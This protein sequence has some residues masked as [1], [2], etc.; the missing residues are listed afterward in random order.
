MLHSWNLRVLALCLATSLS[1]VSA[2]DLS[3]TTGIETSTDLGFVAPSTEVALPDSTTSEAVVDQAPSSATSEPQVQIPFTSADEETTHINVAPASSE[4]SSQ[5]VEPTTNVA[6][7]T[8]TTESAGPGVESSSQ[9]EQLPDTAT[10]DSDIPVNTATGHPVFPK[11]ITQETEFSTQATDATPVDQPSTEISGSPSEAT[12][13]ATGA[14]THAATDALT[15]VQPPVASTESTEVVD[16]TTQ[17]TEPTTQLPLPEATTE[18]SSALQP[19]TEKAP[20]ASTDSAPGPGPVIRSTTEMK[21][22]EVSTSEEAQIPAES[23]TDKVEP[24]TEEKPEPEPTTESQEAQEPASQAPGPKP[25]TEDAGSNEPTSKNEPGQTGAPNEPE[26]TTAP[27]KPTTTEDGIVTGSNGAVVT[28]LPE[29]DKDFSDF[30]GTTTTTDDGGAAIVIFP[31]G[32]FWKPSG[33]LPAGIL[34]PPPGTNPAGAGGG[35]PGG[36]GEGEGE[37]DK[38][39]T[40][41][42]DEEQST[43]KEEK[44]TTEPSTTETTAKSTEATITTE[45]CSA[46]EI[47]D[48]TRTISYYTTDG[49]VT[50]T[51]F[52]D[53]P[54]VASCATGTQATS[55]ETVSAEAEEGEEL[56]IE[57]LDSDI[58][59]DFDSE[60]DEETVEA[61][62]D[63]L[64]EGLGVGATTTEEPTASSTGTETTSEAISTGAE[65]TSDAKTEET[66]SEAT[67][68]RSI[69]IPSTLITTTRNT[70]ESSGT[71]SDGTT[72]QLTSSD[73]IT[74]AT[75]TTTMRTYYP[76]IPYGGPRVET[77]SCNCETTS[78]GERYVVTAPMI[79]G[80]CADYTEFPMS[81]YTTP[82]PAPEPTIFKEP[83]TR[84]DAGTVLVYESYSLSYFAVNTIKVTATVGLGEA[85]TVSTPLPTAT[86]WNGD[87]SSI[88]SSGDKNVRNAVA[89]ACEAALNKF[90]DDTV[91]TDYVSRYERMG[92]ILKVLTFGKAGCTVQ[93]SCDDYGIG[94]KGKDIKDLRRQQDGLTRCGNIDLSNSCKIHIDYCTECHHDG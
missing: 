76:C 89:G 63:A 15:D 14:A 57:E 32:W 55:T 45:A 25:T 73:M 68:E 4:E 61:L 20:E 79:S 44:S 82:P 13:D 24:T 70:D 64:D 37:D 66:P 11:P 3:T 71:T 53:C 33:N 87:G 43:K 62:E 34:P 78:D 58:P 26:K 69:T 46:V 22:P 81:L 31:G 5:A 80:Q 1:G 42:E 50:H 54:T 36:G 67:T 49:T 84:T 17:A 29:Q 39:E 16:P 18:T 93:F 47:E 85:S 41:K 88:C 74:S 6:P 72:T 10:T 40:K 27:P 94:M 51:E 56:D 7:A 60:P 19:T 28:Y 91:Y 83:F 75:A 9:P 35:T 21:A 30:T 92:S 12:R 59:D 52:G 8:G 2:Q 48:C 77:P 86:N 38:N 23:T 65:T 90:E